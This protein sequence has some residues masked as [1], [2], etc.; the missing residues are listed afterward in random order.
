M[1]ASVC[2]VIPAYQEM[3]T[4]GLIVSQCLM[5]HE[6]SSVVVIDD[7]SEDETARIA[8]EKGATVLRHPHNHGKGASLMRGMLRRGAEGCVARGHVG[9]RRP[10]PAAKTCRVCWHAARHWPEHIVIGSRR[11]SGQ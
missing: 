9:W 7:G 6:V 3:A 1:A 10:A 2:V 4:I 11:A 8:T 5:V